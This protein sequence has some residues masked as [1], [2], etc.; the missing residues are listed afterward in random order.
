[1]SFAPHISH[2]KHGGYRLSGCDWKVED[3][4]FFYSMCCKHNIL[5]SRYTRFTEKEG[6]L[7]QT[8]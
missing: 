5:Q 6:L 3:G 1:M 4:A 8:I 7:L 2:I